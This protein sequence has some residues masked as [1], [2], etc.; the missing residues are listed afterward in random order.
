MWFIASCRIFHQFVR[1][2]AFHPVVTFWRR[3][4]HL[5]FSLSSY[6]FFLL[7]LGTAGGILVGTLGAVVGEGGR[8]VPRVPVLVP[9]PRTVLPDL[10]TGIKLSLFIFFFHCILT[11]TCMTYTA[12]YETFWS[13]F[14]FTTRPI[15]IS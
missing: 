15:H 11:G 10:R 3:N 2:T 9:L 1:T 7:G 5:K 6:F 8:L 12:R 13:F 4:F 14:G